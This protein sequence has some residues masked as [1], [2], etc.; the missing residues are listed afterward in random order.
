[1]GKE[2]VSHFLQG[3]TSRPH[4]PYQLLAKG[5][6]VES[7][8]LWST[9][10]L[11]PFFCLLRGLL[12]TLETVAFKPQPQWAG[13]ARGQWDSLTRG[14][15]TVGLGSGTSA[16]SSAGVSMPPSLGSAPKPFSHRRQ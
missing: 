14:Y 15:V 11:R 3:A 7:A 4:C 6:L 2:E 9:S 1:M 5:Q 13:A 8:E 12:L 16:L 10:S